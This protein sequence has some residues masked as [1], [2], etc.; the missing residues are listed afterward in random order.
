MLVAIAPFRC[1]VGVIEI[2]SKPNPALREVNV[3]GT[4]NVADAA[5]SLAASI[6]D[7]IRFIH[8]GSVHAIP[9]AAIGTAIS[10]PEDYD[11]DAVVGQYAK[12]KAEG[13]KLI[14]DR[15]ETGRLQGCIVLP[16]GI[17]GPFN[18][19]VENMKSMV[20]KVANG[21]LRACVAGG[22]DFVDV[23]DV[24]KGIVASC[25]SGRNGE[26]YILSNRRVAIKE[27]CDEVR[28][29][30]NRPP[31]RLVLPIWIAKLVAPFFEAWYD[32]RHEVPLF[33]RYA[34]HTLESNSCFD[35]GKASMDLG[36]YVRPLQETISDMV[37]WLTGHEDIEIR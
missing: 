20:I 7:R 13:A 36:Y 5:E 25:K 3:E 26:S 31:M 14:L 30:S 2:A 33:T 6:P 29:L 32:I 21:T 16:S 19:G 8:I 10:E 1:R 22:Y 37:F 9:E 15:F 28:T 18:F 24:A 23:R 35:H 27:I 11:E 34:L 12:S 4:R 17:I